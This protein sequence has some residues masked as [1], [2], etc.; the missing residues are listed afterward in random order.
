MKKPETSKQRY[1]QFD[2]TVSERNLTFLQERVFANRVCVYVAGDLHHY[3]RHSN[4]AGQHK[5]T[6]GGGGAFHRWIGVD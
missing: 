2:R 4:D 1:R 6:A 3:R 5:I